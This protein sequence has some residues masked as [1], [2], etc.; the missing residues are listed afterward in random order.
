MDRLTFEWSS[1]WTFTGDA[2]P[3]RLLQGARPVTDP[4]DLS[5]ELFLSY[6]KTD[7]FVAVRVHD[8]AREVGDMATL[9]LR[10]FSDSTIPPSTVMRNFLPDC[11]GT[12][13][14]RQQVE[15]NR[16]GFTILSSTV[17]PAKVTLDFDGVC[18]YDSKAGDACSVNPV[19]WEPRSA[20]ARTRSS[21]ASTRSRR[22]TGRIAVAVRQQLRRPQGQRDGRFQCLLTRPPSR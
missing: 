12:R 17:G 20:T 19:R 16:T 15:D 11:Y 8:H 4:R 3:G 9:F 13:D 10:D 2:N 6:T 22:S 1:P 14:E 7:L 21:P 5:A 18:A